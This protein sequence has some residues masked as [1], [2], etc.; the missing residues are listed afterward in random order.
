MPDLH[1]LIGAYVFPVLR[2]EFTA[3]SWRGNLSLGLDGRAAA[4]VMTSLAPHVK[5]RRGGEVP[6]LHLEPDSSL[7]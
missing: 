5:R 3:L 1:L 4:A 2:L 6:S 7:I